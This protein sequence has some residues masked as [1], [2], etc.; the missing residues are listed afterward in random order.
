VR[1]LGLIYQVV[2]PQDGVPYFI[3][4]MQADTA[5]PEN[6]LGVCSTSGDRWTMW[7][8]TGY[9]RPCAKQ[10]MTT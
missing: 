8:P 2:S 6:A 7:R 1:A 3:A 5:K 9:L 10:W 4:D